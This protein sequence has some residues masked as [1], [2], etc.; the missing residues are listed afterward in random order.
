MLLGGTID[1]VVFLPSGHLYP[2]E[3]KTIRTTAGLREPL[4]THVAQGHC[5]MYM[6]GSGT[7]QYLYMD[8]AQDALEG[9]TKH[10]SGGTWDDTVN[11]IAMSEASLAKGVD[12]KAEPD[13]FCFECGVNHI[14]PAYHGPVSTDLSDGMEDE[15]IHVPTIE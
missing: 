14:C 4:P 9:F 3:I 12:P 1:G 6:V 5:Y 15:E 10:F 13:R 2:V 7:I 11:R 8:K